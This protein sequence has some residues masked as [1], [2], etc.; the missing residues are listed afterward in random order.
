VDTS[1]RVERDIHW[2]D[3]LMAAVGI[4][5]FLSPFAFQF[6]ERN[7]AWNA[8]LAGAAVAVIA[9]I[10][11]KK[12]GT[13]NEVL[14]LLLGIWLMVSPWIL[15]FSADSKA[16]VSAIIAGGAVLVCAAWAMKSKDESYRS[17]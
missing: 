16:M 11:I 14:L 8:Y 5:L 9:G 7:I 6:S 17:Q 3:W 15:G 12:R 2:Q 4:L 10:A 1:M 13:W